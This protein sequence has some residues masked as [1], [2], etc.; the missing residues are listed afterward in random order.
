M[1]GSGASEYLE[2]G[3]NFDLKEHYY[4]RRLTD[5]LTK[6]AQI[7]LLIEINLYKKKCPSPVGYAWILDLEYAPINL[8]RESGKSGRLWISSYNGN[9]TSSF[10]SRFFM[11]MGLFSP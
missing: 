10:I 7:L 5:I 3:P 11:D 2:N 6:L 9:P 4:P 8:Y 1:K